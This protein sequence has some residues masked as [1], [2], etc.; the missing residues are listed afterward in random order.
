MSSEYIPQLEDAP[1]EVFVTGENNQEGA[2]SSVEQ[3][4]LQAPPVEAPAELPER[5]TEQA[6][7]HD[8]RVSLVSFKEK[9]S[10][11]STW[12]RSAVTALLLGTAS[13]GHAGEESK[14]DEGA[15][16]VTPITQE[17]RGIKGLRS[18]TLTGTQEYEVTD[19]S[20][21]KMRVLRQDL[22]NVQKTL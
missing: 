21:K 20:G 7:T 17:V 10:T 2:L 15:Y 22:P 19:P 8:E 13:L 11:A 9:L 14:I 12:A 3:A 1:E 4:F 6:F 5:G 18:K 16:T